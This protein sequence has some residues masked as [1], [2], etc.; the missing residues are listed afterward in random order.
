MPLQGPPGSVF[1]V[2]KFS[3]E[4]HSFRPWKGCGGN[5][6]R[7]ASFS[8][9]YGRSLFGDILQTANYIGPELALTVEAP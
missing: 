6:R 4:T 2:G 8:S 1:C 5:L 3:F 9:M 7:T